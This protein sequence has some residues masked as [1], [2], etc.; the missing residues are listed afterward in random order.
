ML[1]GAATHYLGMQLTNRVR[2]LRGLRAYQRCL[3]ACQR[4][5]SACQRGLSACLEGLKA[6]WMDRHMD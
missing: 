2:T 3:R 5:L 4:D 6:G 1:I